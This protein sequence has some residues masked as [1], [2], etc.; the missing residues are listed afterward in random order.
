MKT[1]L[2]TEIKTVDEAKA[3]LRALHTNGES[4]H[5][6]D[7]AKSI[8]NRSGDLLFTTDESVQ[9]DKLMSD[10]YEGLNGGDHLCPVF[11]PCE[12]L[13]ELI[14][15]PYSFFVK[16]LS[17]RGGHYTSTFA[18][19]LANDE[20]NDDEFIDWMHSAEVGDTYTEFNNQTITRT[21]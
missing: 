9:L 4:Y 10:I 3:L 7:S 11:D 1:T 5:P 12:Y 6:E 15:E 19:L 17:G 8:F 18:A 13:N 20:L 21:K 2:P 14:Y 16:D